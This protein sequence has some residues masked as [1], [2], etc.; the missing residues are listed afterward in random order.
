MSQITRKSRGL[1]L[2]ILNDITINF[3]NY[4]TIFLH[5]FDNFFNRL[6][7]GCIRKAFNLLRKQTYVTIMY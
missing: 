4:I 6:L 5:L 2:Q 1:L 7:C 3:L